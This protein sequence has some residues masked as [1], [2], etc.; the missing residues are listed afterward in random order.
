[1]IQSHDEIGP[2]RIIKPGPGPSWLT[3]VLVSLFLTGAGGLAWYALAPESLARV[4]GRWISGPLEIQGLALAVDRQT[5]EL[6]PNATIEIHP[7]QKIGI[8]GLNSNRP[9]NYD[10]HL[11][12]PDFEVRSILGGSSATPRALLP[13]ESFEGPRELRLA[14]RE[15]T[16]E[17]AVFKIISRY[18]AFDFVAR[19]DTA[20][21][22]ADRAAQYRKAYDLD[23]GAG[24]VR[25]K[26]VAALAEAGRQDLAAEIFE[27]ELAEN[28]PDEESLLKLAELYQTL[29]Q[30]PRQVETVR[31]QIE[32]AEKQGRSG[33]PL[34][35]KLADLFR[36]G[37]RPAE[38]AEIYEA[39]LAEASPEES[40][41]YLGRLVDVYRGSRETAKEIE[42]VKRLLEITP[43]GD[44]LAL[45]AELAALY[46]RSGDAEG[47]LAAWRSL[48]DSLPAGPN[49]VNAQRMIGRLLTQAR[50]YDEAAQAYQEALKMDPDN[51]EIILNAAALAAARNDRGGYRAHLA[52]L[53]ALKPDN[54]Q[55]RQELAQAFQDDGQNAQAKAQYLEILKLWPED[56]Q[57]RLR[58]IAF[59]EKTKDRQALVRQYA[60]LSQRRP[61]DKV[62]AYNLGAL[63]FERK[64]WDRAAEAFKKVLALDPDD[65][66]A[67]EYLLVTYQNKR[68]H[69][70]ILEQAM[71]LYRRNPGRTVYR[72]LMLNT[73]ENARDWA[74]FAQVARAVTELE[75]DSPAG[76]E[77]LH[78]AQTRQNQKTEAARS[79]VEI[80]RR[81]PDDEPRKKDKIAAWLRAAS[82]LSGVRQDA[83]ARQAYEK[84]MELDSR[85]QTAAEALLKLNLKEAQ[86][87]GR[88]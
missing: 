2:R 59:L 87:R 84:V 31:R 26:L 41:Q 37:G 52:K 55:H 7:G 49:R 46:E 10:L 77:F 38:A 5:V 6:P 54:L 16:R 21:D 11:H 29:G 88:S 47:R 43:A 67:R 45:W 79:L 61:Q 24:L 33:A 1:M 78:K 48:A 36:D 9:L 74:G 40:A 56:D 17:L 69:Q 34:K 86:T 68:S 82:A 71:E 85:N 66:E 32:L 35:I 62:V 65:L 12:S 51:P 22:P 80:A 75:P 27:A 19:G 60:E 15:G 58:L 3:Y 25:D 14:V 73:C 4:Y 72:T 70:D 30:L 13:D 76:W 18:S 63:L 44:T 81:I 64:D 42:A 20:K 39:L 50:K 57:S 8:V 23:P 28:G 53:V 83:E